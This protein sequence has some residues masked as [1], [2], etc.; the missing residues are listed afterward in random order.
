M[1]H[2]SLAGTPRQAVG[3]GGVLAVLDHVEVETAHV[4]DT[5]VEQLLI[6]QV[7]VVLL[8]GLDDL[9]LQ[10]MRPADR[11]LVERDH[12]FARDQIPGR[13]E[14][15]QIGEQKT[16]GVAYPPI[17]IGGALEDLVRDRH[18]GPIVGRRHPQPDD[19]RP[20]G[21]HDR[22]RQDHVAEGLGHLLTFGVDRES[23][24]QHALVGCPAIHRHRAQQRRL[25][26][27]TVLVRAFEVQ[28]GGKHQFLARLQHTGMGDAGVKPDVQGIGHFLIAG[29]VLAEQVFRLQVEPG[30]D[31]FLLHALC[32]LFDQ[33]D[34]FWMQLPR[35]LVHEEGNR[36]TPGT[37]ARD[38]PVGTAF[39]HALD[40]RLPPVGRE[41]HPLDLGHRRMAQA[42]LFHRDEPL[43]RGAEDDR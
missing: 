9:L 28:I 35:F 18:L 6:D 11:P 22:L 7:E 2:R 16:C 26:P 15:L 25:E 13:V 42:L 32:H 31:A 37:L 24:R 1:E 8:I 23:V 36:D 29:R 41:L 12:L 40:A 19:V 21:L 38:T 10:G 30:L 39:D 43:R 5:E 27:T 17:G 20:Q 34:R 4:G 14:P 3:L 33:R